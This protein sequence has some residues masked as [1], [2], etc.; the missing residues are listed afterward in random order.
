MSYALMLICN[1][2][3]NTHYYLK[4]GVSYFVVYRVAVKRCSV[5]VYN[6]K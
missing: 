6:K 5:L 4:Q 1:W 2:V 3:V